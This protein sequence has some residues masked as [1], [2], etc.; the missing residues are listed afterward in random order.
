MYTYIMNAPAHALTCNRCTAQLVHGENC[1][2]TRTVCTFHT[3]HVQYMYRAGCTQQVHRSDG[4]RR[5]LCKRMYAYFCAI[6][7]PLGPYMPNVVYV[8]IR[9]LTI[10]GTPLGLHMPT[11]VY[12]HIHAHAY[13]GAPLRLQMPNAVLYAHPRKM[14]LTSS[15]RNSD[16][17][18]RRGNQHAAA[19]YCTSITWSCPTHVWYFTHAYCTHQQTRKPVHA[20]ITAATHAKFEAK[21]AQLVTLAGGL[22]S[23]TGTGGDRPQRSNHAGPVRAPRIQVFKA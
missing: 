22:K 10:I 4:T 6:T 18:P 20:Y 2:R 1:T 9:V 3:A 13:I 23:A 14:R 11:A 8:R 7:I 19:Q 12:A 21:W 16:R 17:T 15:S 5:A